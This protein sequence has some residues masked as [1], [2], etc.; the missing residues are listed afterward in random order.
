MYFDGLKTATRMDS[1]TGETDP[2]DPDTDSDGIQDGVEDA[3]QDGIHDEKK[4]IQNLILMAMDWLTVQKTT[5]IM[6]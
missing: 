6:V 3:N 2:R 5:T 4:W 1:L